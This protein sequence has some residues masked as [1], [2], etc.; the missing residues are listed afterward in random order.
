M[1]SSPVVALWRL[2][3]ALA[4]L[5]L[6]DLITTYRVMAAGGREGNVLMRNVI[7]TPM[8]PL[9][10]TLALVFLALLI[11]GSSTRGRPAPRRLLGAAYGLVAIYVLVVLNNIASLLLVR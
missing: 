1:K 6:F 8:A 7:L 3:W 5:Q 9:L 2:F 10:K 11:I 4:I